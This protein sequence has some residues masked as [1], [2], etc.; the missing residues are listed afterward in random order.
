MSKRSVTSR[1]SGDSRATKPAPVKPAST[2]H[3]RMRPG[4]AVSVAGAPL[5]P[6]SRTY[7]RRY[8]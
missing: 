6:P 8:S 7:D 5:T 4:V 3:G 1:P 2:T